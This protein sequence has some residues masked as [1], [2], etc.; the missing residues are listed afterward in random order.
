MLDV[1]SIGMAGVPSS[2][3]EA[4]VFSDTL[5]RISNDA[6]VSHPGPKLSAY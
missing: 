1:A 6:H 4:L 3:D 5:A 2:Q